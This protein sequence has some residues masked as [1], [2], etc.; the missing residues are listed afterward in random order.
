MKKLLFI[1]LLFTCCISYSC[2]GDDTGKEDTPGGQRSCHTPCHGTE[3][4]H[5]PCERCDHTC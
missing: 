3:A 5:C 1:L 2:S 4:R